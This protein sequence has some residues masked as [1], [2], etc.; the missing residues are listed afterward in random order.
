[1]I[2]RA[3]LLALGAALVAAGVACSPA[4]AA[5]ENP[6]EAP[7]KSL[8]PL[9]QP[10]W[11]D[12]GPRQREILAP[13]EPQWNALPSTSKRA[14][15]KLADRV[16]R[17]RGADREKALER[18]R[19]WASLSHEQRRLARNNYRLSKNLDRD[20]LSADWEQYL[21]M[22]PEQRAVLRASGTTSNTAA[23]HAGARTGLAK[24]AARPLPR[25]N[26]SQHA[27]ADR[28]HPAR[29]N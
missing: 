8:L 9:A 13:L 16:P 23:R 18:I 20:G 10:L 28:Q 21:Q 26:G 24:E 11:S 27:A 5:P 2:R 12:L 17:M 29:R 14:W 22:T 19:E 7:R 6:P 15:V 3:A 25:A 4:R 1:M